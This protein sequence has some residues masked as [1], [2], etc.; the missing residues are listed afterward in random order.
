MHRCLDSLGVLVPEFRERCLIEESDLIANII[1]G[2]FEL[3]A[4]CGFLTIGAIAYVVLYGSPLR[5]AKLV[6]ERSP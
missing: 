4:G 6:S 2:S 1:D 5:H 3:V